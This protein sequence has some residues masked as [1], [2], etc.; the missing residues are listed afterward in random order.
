VAK[1]CVRC[2][3]IKAPVGAILSE[4][5]DLAATV[6]MTGHKMPTHP[7]GWQEAG[8]NINNRT[9]AEIPEIG[10]SKGLGEEIKAGSLAHRVYDREAASVGSD[11]ITRLGGGEQGVC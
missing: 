10:Q 11:A 1:E 5:E 8:L 9:R 2:L 7:V 6:D 3:D 4:E